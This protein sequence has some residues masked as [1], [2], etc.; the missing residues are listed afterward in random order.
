M[1]NIL[2]DYNEL[3]KVT[4]MDQDLLS[5]IKTCKEEYG[6]TGLILKDLGLD[7][8]L[9][10]VKDLTTNLKVADE[11]KAINDEKFAELNDK[12]TK[13]LTNLNLVENYGYS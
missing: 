9:N 3:E 7:Q 12:N 13:E 5:K 2:V 6:G 4:K 10:Q 8:D 11:K 1:D